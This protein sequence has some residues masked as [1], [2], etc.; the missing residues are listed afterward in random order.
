ME[1]MFGEGFTGPGGADLI[2]DLVKPLGLDS[3]MT[4]LDIGSGLGGRY[5]GDTC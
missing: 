4:V 2:R 1:R 5:A 3:S